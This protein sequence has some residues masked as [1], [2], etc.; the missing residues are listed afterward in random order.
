MSNSDLVPDM[1]TCPECR[2]EDKGMVVVVNQEVFLGCP[3]IYTQ[4]SQYLEMDIYLL[5]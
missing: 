4:F 1:K 3:P 2:R 5:Q